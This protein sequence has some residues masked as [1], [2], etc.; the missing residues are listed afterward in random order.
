MLALNWLEARQT[1]ERY[2][3]FCAS[4]VL[5]ESGQK[6]QMSNGENLEMFSQMF[7]FVIRFILA[8]KE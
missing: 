6:T 5:S 3:F 7:A 2:Y 8:N 4:N 1:V